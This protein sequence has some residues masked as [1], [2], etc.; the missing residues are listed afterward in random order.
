MLGFYP[1]SV[2]PL[3]ADD[4]SAPV[5]QQVEIVYGSRISQQCVIDAGFTGRVQQQCTVDAAIRSRVTQ[6]CAIAYDI[7]D[8]ARVQAALTLVVPILEQYGVIVTGVPY[9]TI[10]GETVYLDAATVSIDEGQYAWVCQLTLRNPIEINLFD[11]DAEFT[12]SLLGETYS[13]IVNDKQLARREAVDW[14]AGVNGIGPAARYAAPRAAPITK[15][16]GAVLA[17]D[18]VAELFGDAVEWEIL[19]WS[20]P[21]NRLAAQNQAPMD[22]LQALARA[23]GAVVQSDPDGTLRV[24]Y[25]YPVA[26]PAYA[27]A[28]ADHE[29]D[30]IQHTLSTSERLVS[31]G[32][33]DKLRILDAQAS[34]END[35]LEF[36]QDELDPA[37]GTLRLFPNPWRDG[38]SIEH[39]S[40]DRVSATLDGIETETL[41]ETVE[42][43]GGKGSVSKPIHS[44]ETLEWLYADLTGV[45]FEADS[46]EFT[47]THAT[48]TESLLRITYATR[49][50]AYEAAAYE[51]AEVQFLVKEAA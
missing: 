38:L 30:D 5:S 21:P 31:Q 44:V 20:L 26:V 39:T 25:V 1:I 17:T 48:L 37:R 7:R 18:V 16:W 15:T 10:N 6:Q 2:A 47:T 49:F 27:A 34:T 14:S 42:V 19:N 4:I 28:I 11:V 41:T 13:F 24:R 32:L 3:A 36:E 33:V 50:I 22:I 23:A 8:T 12:V 43:I 45:T 35:A 40:D 29:Y 51:D 46:R 9:A